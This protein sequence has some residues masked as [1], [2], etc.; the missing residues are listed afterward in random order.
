MYE[1]T[2]AKS[3]LFSLTRAIYFVYRIIR[4]FEL[5][6]WM[7]YKT[8]DQQAKIVTNKFASQGN[9][10]F[11]DKAQIIILGNKILI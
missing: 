5:S 8:V 4:C 10:R 2:R 11:N 6:P 3:T 7:K 9:N 1:I